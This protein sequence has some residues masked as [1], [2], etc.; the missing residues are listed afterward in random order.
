LPNKAPRGTSDILP[1]EQAYWKYIQQQADAICYL[2]GYQRIDTPIFEETS[3]FTRGVGEGTEVVQKQ[4]YTMEDGGGT[5]ITLRPECTAPVCRAYVEHG[6]HNLPQ[7][8]RLYYF[9]PT[10]RYERPQA[11]RYRQHWQFGFEAIGAIDP[12]LDAEII[13]M[14]WQFYHMLGLSDLSLKLNSIGCRSCRPSFLK[15]LKQHYSQYTDQLCPDCTNRLTRNPLRLLDCKN[16]DCQQIAQSAPRS[17]DH[18]CAECNGHFDQLKQY[19]KIME[20]PFELDPYLVRGLDYYT[21]TVFEFQPQEGGAQSAIGGGGRYDG[22]IEE[23]EGK[24]TPGI[25]LA[26]GIERIILNLKRDNI[27]VPSTPT[28]QIYVACLGEQAKEEAIKVASELR[29]AGIS[30]IESLGSRSLKAQMR[31]AN[32]LGVVQTIIIGEDEIK[33]GTVTLR[34]MQKGEQ[35][36]IPREDLAARLRQCLPPS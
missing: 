27:T 30:T 22:L 18:L 6:M 3:L 12:A 33:N 15:A 26:T 14:G 29:R 13:E 4:M 25:G 35:S 17:T 11:G 1:A 7:P 21:R 8:V 2:Y 28:P 31:Q 9:A 20:L 34:D 23:L 24:P 19:L 5:S 16:P 36:I 10:F 32:A